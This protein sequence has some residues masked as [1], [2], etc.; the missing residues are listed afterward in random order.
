VHVCSI[1]DGIATSSSGALLMINLKG[2]VG[3]MQFLS[4][5]I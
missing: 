1:Y 2:V 4:S 3:Q 5:L